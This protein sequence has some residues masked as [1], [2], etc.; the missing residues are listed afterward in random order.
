MKKKTHS[1]SS[2]FA[3][4]IAICM[5]TTA[6]FLYKSCLLSNSSTTTASTTTTLS[7]LLPSPTITN[8]Q[9][10]NHTSVM[11]PRLEVVND[12][13]PVRYGESYVFRQIGILTPLNGPKD[14]KLLPLIGRVMNNRRGLWQYYSTSNQYNNIQL[15]VF[16][17]NKP[18][19][20]EYGVDEL[21]NGD[22]VGVGG[23]DEVYSVQL[24][25]QNG[26]VYIA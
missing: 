23:L 13:P 12:T 1:L 7:S 20:Y 2:L 4:L 16:V 8:N 22:T 25:E 19:M 10:N 18:G 11:L 21:Y 3:F 26:P 9:Y 17:K 6:F 24:Y 5:A 14:G 15:S